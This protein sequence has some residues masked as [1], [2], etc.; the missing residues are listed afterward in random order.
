MDEISFRFNL[1]PSIGVV[2]HGKLQGS[3]SPWEL[4]PCGGNLVDWKVLPV[5]RHPQEQEHRVHSVRQ[6]SL[7]ETPGDLG[8]LCHTLLLLRG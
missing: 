8:K 5:A 1:V 3:R 6:Q 2:S 4:L 7:A